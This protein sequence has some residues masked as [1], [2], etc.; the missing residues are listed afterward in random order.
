MI[1]VTKKSTFWLSENND[2]CLVPESLGTDLWVALLLGG[3]KCGVKP[4]FGWLDGRV[5]WTPPT[6]LDDNDDVM[7]PRV[8]CDWEVDDTGRIVGS[9][10]T[11]YACVIVMK[12]MVMAAYLVKQ[13]PVYIV[14][15]LVACNCF[16]G[17]SAESSH[18]S[19][20][21]HSRMRTFRLCSH[22]ICTHRS[23]KMRE[24]TTNVALVTISRDA[25]VSVIDSIPLSFAW[26][27]QCR[28]RVRSTTT[29]EYTWKCSDPTGWWSSEVR[30]I[31]FAL[32]W[33][34]GFAAEV[35]LE[36]L[37]FGCLLIISC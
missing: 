24:C 15:P 4:V 36:I 27:K 23:W 32:R 13:A 7:C 11:S 5:V 1:K 6:G 25:V 19:F 34:L 35:D 33:L 28:L 2:L 9:A 10:R 8:P 17:L 20:M 29:N 12:V 22:T 31:T 21:G 26:Q 16:R 37:G 30:S 18:K 14:V 3:R